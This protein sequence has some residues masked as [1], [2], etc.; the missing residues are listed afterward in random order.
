MR[1]SRR[2]PLHGSCAALLITL[3][4]GG[5]P[6]AGGQVLRPPDTNPWSSQETSACSDDPDGL[7][8]AAGFNC[9]QVITLCEPSSQAQLISATHVKL[10]RQAPLSLTVSA[11]AVH[12]DAELSSLP[13]NGCQIPMPQLGWPGQLGLA[14]RATVCPVQCLQDNP[15]CAEADGDD[16]SP[17]SIYAVCPNLTFSPPHNLS[18][19]HR[20][21]RLSAAGNALHR[22]AHLPLPRDRPHSHFAELRGRPQ[23]R[24][25]ATSTSSWNNQNGSLPSVM[26]LSERGTL[27]AA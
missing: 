19:C 18:V 6:P 16:C 4:I 20:R 24:T 12:V 13:D 7:L 27:R 15:G 11:A 10:T 14:T 21:W 3:H 2:R 22:R 25:H 1:P 8:A 9:D 17:G 5:A 26:W 23:W